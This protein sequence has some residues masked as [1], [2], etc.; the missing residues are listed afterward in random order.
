MSAACGER[1]ALC[2]ST[3]EAM[4]ADWRGRIAAAVAIAVLMI[5]A[6]LSGV[7]RSASPGSPDGRSPYVPAGYVSVF[8]DEF[9]GTRFDTAKW[10][11]R[12]I[13]ENGAKDFLNDEQQRYR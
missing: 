9:D 6:A 1:R 3:A 2:F 4:M 11:T 8:A 13:Y 12:L 5:G 10:W 7:A